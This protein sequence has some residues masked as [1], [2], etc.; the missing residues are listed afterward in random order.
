[1][2]DCSHPDFSAEVQVDRLQD[3][4]RFVASVQI[5]CAVCK[6]PFVFVTKDV[7][8]GLLPDDPTTSVDGTEARWPIRPLNGQAGGLMTGFTIRR[9]DD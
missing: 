9:G 1:M 7:Q 5:H 4:G 6:E 3:A 8:S 2:S